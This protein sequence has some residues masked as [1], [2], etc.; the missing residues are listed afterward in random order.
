MFGFLVS[1]AV[2]FLALVFSSSGSLR[3]QV[4]EGILFGNLVLSVKQNSSCEDNWEE[5]SSDP[6]DVLA[7]Y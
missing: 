4:A 6:K 5:G 3:D 2:H 1:E 7:S